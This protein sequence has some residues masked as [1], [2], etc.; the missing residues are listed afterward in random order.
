MLGSSRADGDV[1]TKLGNFS[2]QHQHHHSAVQHSPVSSSAMINNITIC[3][4]YVS[5]EIGKI[6]NSS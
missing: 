3:N 5:Y 4:K 2:R 6:I 1:E